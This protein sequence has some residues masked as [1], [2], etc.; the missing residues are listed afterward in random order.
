MLQEDKL[1]GL[2]FENRA[3]SHRL[4]R[5]GELEGLEGYLVWCFQSAGFFMILMVGHRISIE[6]VKNKEKIHTHMKISELIHKHK[7]C[8]ENPALL[9]QTKGISYNRF[10]QKYLQNTDVVHFTIR[11]WKFRDRQ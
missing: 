8:Y 3:E 11:K 1:E 5:T 9:L 4:H 6:K 2:N 10:Q 7:H